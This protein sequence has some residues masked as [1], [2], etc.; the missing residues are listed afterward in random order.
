V[1]SAAIAAGVLLALLSM[2]LGIGAL[3]VGSMF[4]E[5]PHPT[6][7]F[8]IAH[9]KGGVEKTPPLSAGPWEVW[10][11]A[12]T[13]T[14]QPCSLVITRDDGS[15]VDRTKRASTCS[16]SGTAT[17]GER[18]TIEATGPGLGRRVHV[19]PDESVFPVPIL[20]FLQATV[21]TFLLSVAGVVGAL[22]TKPRA[23]A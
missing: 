17:A 20:R 5:P 11:P 8:E 14:P 9:A 21:C 13:G 10:I 1:R 19:G 15:L 23:P 3:V 2:A 7:G 4:L 16:A 12:T 22:F 18:W 6:F